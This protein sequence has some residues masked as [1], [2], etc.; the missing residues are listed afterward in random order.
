MPEGLV[1]VVGGSEL[2]TDPLVPWLHDCG[3]R[4]AA[5]HDGYAAL[6][7]LRAERADLLLLNVV[8]PV[9]GAYHLLGAMGREADLMSIPTVI[10]STTEGVGVATSSNVHHLFTP[11][12]QA[13]FERLIRR[14]LGRHLNRQR[15]ES[16]ESPRS[17][18]SGQP[19]V[20]QQ[21]PATSESG[22][23][24][25][26]RF[27]MPPIA[28]NEELLL[29]ETDPGT[30]ADGGT[31]HHHLGEGGGCSRAAGFPPDGAITP[32]GDPT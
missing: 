3:A 1:L 17:P 14:L 12:G 23:V 13:R 20:Y 10:I 8:T 22:C 30:T 16:G 26:D 28:G 15:D 31:S 18:L 25:P 2:A 24:S 19:R 29:R 32:D 9:V 11:F 7:M 4:T 6:E 21:I 5:A 27:T